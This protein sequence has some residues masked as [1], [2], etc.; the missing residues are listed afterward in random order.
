MRWRASLGPAKGGA[1]GKTVA[2]VVAA[3]SGSRA[4]GEAPKQY[5]MIGGRSL[6]AHAIDHLNHPEV[7]EVHVVIGSGQEEAYREAIGNRALPS[8]I[9]GGATRRDSV[10]NGLE[11]TC[12]PVRGGFASPLPE[13]A[14]G[15]STP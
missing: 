7:D 4:G 1:M 15:R 12:T 11:A 14:V 10:V 6:L 3:G 2:L 9:L 8:P 5:R 13:Q